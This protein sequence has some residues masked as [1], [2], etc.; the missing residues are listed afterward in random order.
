[1]MKEENELNDK[2]NNLINLIKRFISNKNDLLKL[3]KEKGI[4]LNRNS[5]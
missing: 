4:N 1:M 2:S 3:L 5:A